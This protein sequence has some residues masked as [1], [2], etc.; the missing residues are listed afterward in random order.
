M[1]S[2]REA[3]QKRNCRKLA[4]RLGSNQQMTRVG[5]RFRKPFPDFRKRECLLFAA[6][7]PL[8]YAKPW[9]LGLGKWIFG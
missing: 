7:L 2:D 1:E 5:G 4:S 3:E 8:D 6:V 9:S